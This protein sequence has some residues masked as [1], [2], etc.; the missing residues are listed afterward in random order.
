VLLVGGVGFGVSRAADGFDC[1]QWKVIPDSGSLRLTYLRPSDDAGRNDYRLDGTIRWDDPRALACFSAGHVDWGYEHDVIY[2]RAFHR[3]IWNPEFGFPDGAG[4]YIDAAAFDPSGITTLGFGIF[5]PETLEAGVTYRFSYQLFLPNDPPAGQHSIVLEGQVL[6]KQ[7]S[8]AGPWCVGEDKR[9]YTQS[10]PPF[11]GKT[12]GF[13]V[14][15]STCW[16]WHRYQDPTSCDSTSPVSSNPTTTAHPLPKPASGSTQP[17]APTSATSPTRTVTSPPIA[18]TTVQ[19]PPKPI[20][21][22]VTANAAPTPTSPPPPVTHKPP[23]P[24]AVTLYD[25]IGAGSVGEFTCSRNNPAGSSYAIQSF[26]VPSGVHVLS[27]VTVGVGARDA[28]TV[29]VRRGGSVVASARIGGGLDANIGVDLGRVRVSP[30][31]SLELWVGDADGWTNS[32]ARAA[33]HLFSV[34]RTPGDTYPS[35]NYRTTNNCPGQAS[36]GHDFGVDMS[37][38]ITGSTS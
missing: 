17:P 37:A 34:V 11:I 31:E 21:P 33:S 24:R 8:R 18:T 38:R 12:R 27:K 10:D 32:G 35:G 4:P 6:N 19:Q 3:N 14:T 29:A 2:Q 13:S 9:G 26:V 16:A 25:T 1:A 20:Q 7:C 15:G 30:G 28:F 22:P 36:P 5:R 23:S